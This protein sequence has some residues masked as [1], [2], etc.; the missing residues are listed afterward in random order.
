[1]V[2]MG[3]HLGLVRMNSALLTK[4][5]LLSPVLESPKQIDDLDSEL[6]TNG[7][8]CGRSP[9]KEPVSIRLD[10]TTPALACRWLR[11]TMAS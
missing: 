9:S 1:M 5:Q 11:R 7:N 3:E 4:Q 2:H 6:A 8:Y 10:R